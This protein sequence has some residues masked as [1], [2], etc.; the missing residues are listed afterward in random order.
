MRLF[1]TS[2]VLLCALLLACGGAAPAGPANDGAMTAD[3]L[4]TA[5][6]VVTLDPNA[7]PA[8]GPAPTAV[9]IRGGRVTWVGPAERF[10]GRAARR[11]DRPDAVVVP[12]LVDSHAHL[13]GLGRALAELDL[14]GTRSADEVA[15]KVRAATGEGWITG[16][17]WDQNDWP[18]PE[19]PDRAPLDAAAPARPVALTR[20]DGHA[21]W[22]N[23]AA[24]RAAGIDAATA[25]PPGGRILRDAQGEPTGVLVD[26][27]MDLLR[28]AIPPPTPG[29]IRAWITAAVGEC[30]RVGL[31]GVHD[32]GASAREVAVMREMAAAGELLLRVHV[33]LY[34][35]D[36]EIGPLVDAGPQPGEFVSVY[37]VKLFADGA[38]GSRG[39]WLL[40]P[41]ADAPDTRGIP[42]LHGEALRARVR[43]YAE[44]GFQVGVHAIGDAAA[45]DVLDAFAAVLTPG[46]D[47][48]FRIEHTQIITPEDQQRM[49]R[50]GVL[51]LVQTTH[52]T[53]DMPW[54][55]RRLGPE[56]IRNAYAW[57]SL[58]RR[59]VR[60]S[61]GSDFPVERPDPVQGLYAAVTRQDA[62]GQPPGGWY[63][64]EA[65]TAEEALRGF[66]VDAAWAGFAEHRRG[67]IAP[68]MDADFTLLDE[69]PLGVAPDR[70]DDLRVRG[71]VVAGRVVFDLGGN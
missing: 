43:A 10:T 4:I 1:P 9:A 17:G 60:L 30:H 57:R 6:R 54:A 34:G 53:S 3:L 21:L 62:A 70:L 49:A 29:Q 14:T 7:S 71:V 5:R 36:P 25:D 63:P 23:A 45:R 50:L 55:E 40:G 32:A 67:R 56:R 13:T 64:E 28:Q 22:A 16:R 31:T 38:L 19:F 39:A 33:L 47:R 66:T 44:R 65:L 2:A 42:I 37:G 26:A 58:M 35:D 59:G 20:I 27:A 46:N 52:A 18:V 11:L 51:A 41:Y 48:R 69:D 61:L 24:M 15:A 68:G 12:G 8:G